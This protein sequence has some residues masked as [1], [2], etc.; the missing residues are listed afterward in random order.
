MEY[1]YTAYTTDRKIIEGRIQGDNER[2]AEET[3]YRAG[4]PRVLALKVAPAAF[5]KESLIPTLFGVRTQDKVDFS[6]Q[7]ATLLEAGINVL[8]ALTILQ[9][10]IA[11]PALRK[12]VDQIVTEVQDG[13]SLSAAM[14]HHPKVFSNTYC[15]VVR[16]SEQ[17]GNL[18]TGLRQVA[19]T[20][21]KQA[22]AV[23]KTRRALSY[24]LLIVVMAIVVFT[25]LIVV[26]LPPLVALFASM[27]VVLPWP[28]L[29]VL[30]LSNFLIDYK[31]QIL[32]TIVALAAAIAIYAKT[33]DGRLEID[34]LML[35]APLI[36]QLNIMRA[37]A[38][39]CETSAS[40]L[41]AGLQLTQIMDIAVEI[42]GN[43]VLRKAFEEVRDRLV[44]GE[45]LSGPLSRNPLFPQMVVEMVVVGEEAGRLEAT[46]DN[47]ARN[48]EEKADARMAQLIGMI[49]PTLT[50]VMGILVAIIALSMFMPMYSIIG[51]LK[52]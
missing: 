52:G 41:K 4:Y 32:I 50:V 38:Q 22:L 3:L 20:M 6:N 31:F 39:F 47:L 35:K 14:G 48:Y 51:Q 7:L 9:K 11:R 1:I 17:S 26:I 33:Q 16:A 28:T 27:D 25:V 10:Q 13:S 44:Q 5:D 12:V 18:E 49:E 24:P 2:A 15:Q 23:R 43:R 21:E 19:R 42:T 8:R 30:A 34:R 46:M 36:G 29:A 37:M 40:L 45:G